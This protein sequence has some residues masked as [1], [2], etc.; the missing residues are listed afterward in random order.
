[1][2]ISNTP[3]EKNGGLTRRFAVALDTGHQQ[4]LTAQVVFFSFHSGLGQKWGTALTWANRVGVW[5]DSN[6]IPEH[7]QGNA[8][9]LRSMS[10]KAHIN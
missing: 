8:Q 5:Q 2:R 4:T 10:T 6:M 1:L 7:E 9:I 3:P